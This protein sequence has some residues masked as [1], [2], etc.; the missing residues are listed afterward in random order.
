MASSARHP[1]S[2]A[3][4]PPEDTALWRTN[5]YPELRDLASRQLGVVSR[6][7]LRVRG[8]SRHR[9]DTEIT[10][11]RWTEVAPTVIAL[12]NVSL[13]R[14]QRMWLGVLHA[15]PM[16]ASEVKVGTRLSKNSCSCAGLV[17][18]SLSSSEPVIWLASAGVRRV[19]AEAT[20]A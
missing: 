1:D 15:G 7:Q 9:V 11:G 17:T 5:R 8:W 6:E 19:A 13:G 3:V 14:R 16:S 10:A 20:A 18:T 12:Q 4:P 2:S